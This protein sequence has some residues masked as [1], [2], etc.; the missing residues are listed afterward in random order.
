MTA[1][2]NPSPTT[3]SQAVPVATP[4]TK[5]DCILAV[6]RSIFSIL[7]NVSQISTIPC[8]KEAA[9]IACTLL[10]MLQD[11]KSNKNAYKGIV[12]EICTLLV[13][14]SM[15][16]GE[17]SDSLK[18]DIEVLVKDLDMIRELCLRLVSRN[19]VV[20]F[21][22]SRKDAS[23]LSEIRRNVEFTFKVFYLKST[24]S[25]RAIQE[26]WTGKENPQSTQLLLAELKTQRE[27]MKKTGRT[28]AAL[29]IP[30]NIPAISSGTSPDKSARPARAMQEFNGKHFFGDEVQTTNI[31][32]SGRDVT[33]QSPIQ[34]FNGNMKFWGKVTTVNT[35]R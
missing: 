23:E 24:I 16:P 6:S 9:T 7:E 28:L 12:Q 27:F 33:L 8:L 15:Q 14:I 26:T 17:M 31:N 2:S 32:L 19:R 20:R 25:I 22:L 1:N 4:T 5:S 34:S 3:P 21:L 10:Q 30:A 13:C 11:M 29:R 35:I 18:A